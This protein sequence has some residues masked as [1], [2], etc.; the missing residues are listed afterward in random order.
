M[1]PEQVLAYEMTLSANALAVKNENKKIKDAV[2]KKELS[3]KT[4]MVKNAIEMGLT[5]GQSDKLANVSEDF[6]LSI[7]RQ[8]SAN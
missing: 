2:D 7:Q 5:V 6:V 3:M 8:L 4:E 1:T